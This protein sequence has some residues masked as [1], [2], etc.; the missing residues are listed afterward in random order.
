MNN[1]LFKK[2]LIIYWSFGCHYFF[3]IW[4]QTFLSHKRVVCFNSVF[5][6]TCPLHVQLELVIHFISL[7]MINHT[8]WPLINKCMPSLAS[9]ATATVVSCTKQ[10]QMM[11]PPQFIG[12]YL[13]TSQHDNGQSYSHFVCLQKL[14]SIFLLHPT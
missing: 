1:T 3:C 9:F 6:H 7:T 10:K 2:T 14:M 4:L 11:P 5:A 12:I 8:V 13:Y